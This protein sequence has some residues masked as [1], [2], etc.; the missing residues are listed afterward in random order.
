MNCNEEIQLT[1]SPNTP[2]IYSG[3]ILDMYLYGLHPKAKLNYIYTYMHAQ[4]KSLKQDSTQQTKDLLSNCVTC[5]LKS[6][7]IF[8]AK[9]VQA[10]DQARFYLFMCSSGTKLFSDDLSSKEME[11]HHLYRLSIIS[12]HG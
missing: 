2:T 11:T 1:P 4:Q 9:I 10:I 8:S 7:T 6:T 3:Y 12:I 5:F